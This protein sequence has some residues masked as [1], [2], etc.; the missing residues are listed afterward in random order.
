[1]KYFTVGLHGDLNVNNFSGKKEM[2]RWTRVV[3][4][5]GL[6]SKVLAE[7]LQERG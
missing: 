3:E 5:G 1:M 2:R 7:A 6:P 4:P